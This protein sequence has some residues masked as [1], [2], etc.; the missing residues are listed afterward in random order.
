M[1]Y[2]IEINLLA[3]SQLKSKISLDEAVLLDYLYWL[4]S[5]PSDEVEMMRCYKSSKNDDIFDKR[6]TWFDYGFYIKETPILRGK[7]KGTITPKI[8]NLEKEGFIETMLGD[9][10]KKYVRLLPKCDSL[11][12]NLNTPVQK[13][14]HPP[15][16]KLNID[17]NTIV[18]NNTKDK[19]TPSVVSIIRSYFMEKYKEKVG[20]EPEMSFGKEGKLLKDKLGRYSVDQLKDLVEQFFNSKVGEDLGY[21]LS[22]CLSSGVMNQ[23][24]SKKLGKKKKPYYLGKPMSQKE[25]GKWY[26]VDQGIWLEFAGKKEEIEWK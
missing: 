3:L 17:N 13:T 1:R 20:V 14:K 5:S 9:D 8:T 18:D 12:R 6:F 10:C 11:F 23:W 2:K 7:T 16:R 15:F 24:Q 19:A 26:V 22:I 21:T 25:N 4:C